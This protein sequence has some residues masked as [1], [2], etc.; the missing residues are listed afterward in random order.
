MVLKCCL[1]L[2]V[3]GDNTVFGDFA[4]QVQKLV[5]LGFNTVKLPFAFP[6]LNN[7]APGN[8]STAC[9][10]STAR[11]IQVHLQYDYAGVGHVCRHMRAAA[12]LCAWGPGHVVAVT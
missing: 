3:Q 11:T 9:T 5:A 2:P 8:V 12:S 7:A 4:T 1:G 10:T 6:I